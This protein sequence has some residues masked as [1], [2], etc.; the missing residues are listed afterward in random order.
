MKHG[1]HAN[2][3]KFKIVMVDQLVLIVIFYKERELQ[4]IV[5]LYLQQ[6]DKWLEVVQDIQ[7]SHQIY[8]LLIQ[9]LK[10][11]LTLNTLKNIG[12]TC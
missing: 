8:H 2:H 5:Y 7:S 6:K 3:V 4:L 11:M 1:S 10:Q 12:I 9:M